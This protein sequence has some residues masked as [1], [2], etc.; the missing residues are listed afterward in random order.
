M[1]VVD[2]H[3]V[4]KLYNGNEENGAVMTSMHGETAVS[5][6]VNWLFSRLCVGKFVH[7]E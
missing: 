6:I 3:A 2:T 1:F 5:A 7:H 4:P